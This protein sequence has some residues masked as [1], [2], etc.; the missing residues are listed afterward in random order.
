VEQGTLG[1]VLLGNPTLDVSRARVKGSYNQPM[2]LRVY[3]QTGRLWEAQQG[4]RH[5]DQIEFGSQLGSGIYVAELVQGTRRY[6][7]RVVKIQ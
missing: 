5:G 7:V 3:D 6:T 1:L 2:R 4:L